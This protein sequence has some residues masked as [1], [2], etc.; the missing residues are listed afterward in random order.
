M[1]TKVL[2]TA[3]CWNNGVK[4]ILGSPHV[5][6]EKRWR[7]FMLLYIFSV[8]G[9]CAIAQVTLGMATSL[10][11]DSLVYASGFRLIGTT[12]ESLLS[13]L[14]TDSVFR[15]KSKKL[16]DLKC[17]VIMCNVLFPGT[18][19]IA[20]PDVNE[21]I[22]LD[23]LEKVLQ[24]AR[25]AGVENLILG[26]GGARRL[27]ES[28]DQKKAKDDFVMLAGKMAMLAQRY[29]V[30]IILENLNHTETNFLNTLKDAAEIV[31]RV[32]HPS[33]RLNAD[34]YHM[35]REDE[36]PEEIVRA[37]KLIVYCEIAEEDGRTLPGVKG[38]DFRPYL[39][40]LKKIKFKG[41]M[42][43]EGNTSDLKKEVPQA[44]DFLV[45]ALDNAGL[46]VSNRP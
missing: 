37:G 7:V 16:N 38:E 25:A 5:S 29:G 6:F 11:N 46:S 10:K 14:A 3:V 32:N 1:K 26:S 39:L 13:P 43:I 41:P 42:I 24:R 8:Y 19:K 9:Q 2:N 23:Y 27:P 20:G 45:K 30:R 31:R 17:K 15:E 44:F 4:N 35:L 36:S 18:I 21:K 33:L 28:F 34:I 22:V 12:V 40:A